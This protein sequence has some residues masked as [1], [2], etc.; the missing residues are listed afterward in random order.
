VKLGETSLSNLRD[1]VESG[2]RPLALLYHVLPKRLGTEQVKTCTGSLELKINK[3]ERSGN[4]SGHMT[5]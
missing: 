4:A 5:W 2:A 1:I 3:S